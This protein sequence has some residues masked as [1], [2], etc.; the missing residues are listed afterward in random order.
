MFSIK[1]LLGVSL[2]LFT[3]IGTAES[4]PKTGYMSATGNSELEAR[5]N[6]DQMAR[7]SKWACGLKASPTGYI[8]IT[9]KGYGRNWTAKASYDC[10]PN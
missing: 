1:W 8:R 2:A 3:L 9:S 6:A 10:A 7:N 4:T 5:R